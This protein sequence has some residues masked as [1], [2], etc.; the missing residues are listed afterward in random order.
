MVPPRRPT[1]GRR[2][3]TPDLPEIPGPTADERRLI[4]RI[5]RHAGYRESR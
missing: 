1:F 2:K 4:D 5:M 3:D